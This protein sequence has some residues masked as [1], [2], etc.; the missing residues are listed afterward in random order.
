MVPV[1]A[2]D[3][4]MDTQILRP[5]VTALDAGYRHSSAEML[6]YFLSRITQLWGLPEWSPV[7][8]D[9]QSDIADAI[10]IYGS[11][12]EK[13]E[14]F[15]DLLGPLYMDLAS[16]GGRKQLAQFFSPW[17][18]CQMMAQMA[19]VENPS[20]KRGGDLVRVCDPACGSGAMLLAYANAVLNQHG[21]EALAGLSLTGVDLDPYCALMTA[22]GLIANCNVHGFQ[23]GEIVVMRGNAL[24]PWSELDVTVHATHPS[25]AD[26][27]IAPANHPLR[28]AALAEAAQRNGGNYL[29]E[30]LFAE[31]G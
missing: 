15:V 7:P 21:A 26:C 11:M 23:L 8:A 17:P 9:V 31:L 14:P 18:I 1:S 22:T 10:N 12:V 24:R 19:G 4:R 13:Q 20:S 2:Y 25:L 6:R 27:D 29:Q 5:L 28:I 30:S 16:R 3:L